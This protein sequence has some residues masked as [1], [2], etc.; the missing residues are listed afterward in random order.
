MLLSLGRVSERHRIIF[1]KELLVLFRHF[2]SV[3]FFGED[4]RNEMIRKFG[5]I[6][7]RTEIKQSNTCAQA[8]ECTGCTE[9][10]WKAVIQNCR[11]L[12]RLTIPDEVGFDLKLNVSPPCRQALHTLTAF[13]G[14]LLLS[15]GSIYRCVRRQVSGKHKVNVRGTILLVRI[16]ERHNRGDMGGGRKIRRNINVM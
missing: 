4:C 6:A 5:R 14:P 10:S 12:D 8:V 7:R 2:R 3:V 9:Q 15:A 1:P 13:I 16:A 11:I